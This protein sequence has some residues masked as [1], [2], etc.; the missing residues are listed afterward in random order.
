M[1]V[2]K[3]WHRGQVLIVKDAV[4]ASVFDTVAV[5]NLFA[6]SRYKFNLNFSLFRNNYV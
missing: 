4:M 3:N 5:Q 2:I 6:S 1:F